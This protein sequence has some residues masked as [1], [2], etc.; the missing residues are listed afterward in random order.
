MSCYANMT[1]C[2]ANMISCH[3]HSECVPI[4]KCRFLNQGPKGPWAQNLNPSG[5][6][7]RNHC[8]GPGKFIDSHIV[9]FHDKT[10]D[11]LIWCQQV[12]GPNIWT[13]GSESPE[14]GLLG[15]R[16]VHRH[17]Y[18]RVLREN[19][20]VTFLAHFWLLIFSYFVCFCIRLPLKFYIFSVCVMLYD[21]LT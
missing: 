3:V 19:L 21:K 18:S 17:P 2:Y 12:L 5:N 20:K 14:N 1:S 7:L 10:T 8:W 6:H 9:G 4:E 13:P 16:R 11:F 15:S